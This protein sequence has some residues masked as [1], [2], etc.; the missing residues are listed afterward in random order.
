MFK[1]FSILFFFSTYSIA[2]DDKSLTYI[3]GDWDCS[4]KAEKDLKLTNRVS[5]NTRDMT[6]V[7]K[8]TATFIQG[9]N[10]ESTI[11]SLAIG[12]FKYES[13]ILSEKITDISIEIIKDDSGFLKGA[14]D[15]LK[16]AM[17]T[18]KK[19]LLTL[20]L[21]ENSWIQLN[22][23]TNESTKCKKIYKSST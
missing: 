14:K 19:S 3:H 10:S 18:E 9:V 5:F 11:S 6:F 21:T 20:S 16:E 15:S 1:F 8:G 22:K 4:P 12:T 23:E 17:L 2:M 7:H 13:S